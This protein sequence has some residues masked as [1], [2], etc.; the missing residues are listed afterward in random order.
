MADINKGYENGT[1]K[2][3]DARNIRTCINHFHPSVTQSDNN[4]NY[5]L[6]PGASPTLHLNQVGIQND[7]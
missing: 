1:P 2:I 4:G 5:G 7:I 6:K 3:S